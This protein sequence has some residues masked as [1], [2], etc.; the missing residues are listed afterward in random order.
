MALRRVVILGGGYGGACAAQT[1]LATL[2]EDEVWLCDRFCGHHVTSRGPEPGWI[3]PLS[4]FLPLQPR[5]VVLQTEVHELDW[6]GHRVLTDRGVVPYDLL[7]LALGAWAEPCRVSGAQAHAPSLGAL[8]TVPRLR[9]CVRQF[10]RRGRRAQVVVLGN[11]PAASSFACAAARH[12]G[13][14]VHVSVVPTAPEARI[15][16]EELEAEGVDF[17]HEAVATAVAAHGVRLSQGEELPSDMTVWAGELEAAA[18]PAAAGLSCSAGGRVRCDRHLELV[19]QPGIFAAGADAAVPDGRGGLVAPTAQAAI[20]AG[21]LAGRNI[22]HIVCGQELEAFQ[23]DLFG[24][25]QALSQQHAVARRGSLRT[26]GAGRST[27]SDG[28]RAP[29]LYAGSGVRLRT[30]T[31][32]LSR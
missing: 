4:R 23:P 19:G 21:R 25:W 11:G 22:A 24:P 5:L 3:I 17:Y 15:V 2:E 26:S 9:R 32:R 7:L 28:A 12:F 8:D 29:W 27:L 6:R 1:L 16:P 18:L 14:A 10:A 30:V 13:S 20:Q 31:E